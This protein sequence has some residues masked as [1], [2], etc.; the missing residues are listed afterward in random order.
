MSRMG[1][2][3]G[4]GVRTGKV[5]RAVRVRGDQDGKGGDSCIGRRRW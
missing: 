2:E 3:G 5:A 4:E 1:G